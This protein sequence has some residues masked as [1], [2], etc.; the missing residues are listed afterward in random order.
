MLEEPITIVLVSMLP[1]ASV[2][3]EHEVI[4]DKSGRER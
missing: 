4:V 1:V 2:F 3:W